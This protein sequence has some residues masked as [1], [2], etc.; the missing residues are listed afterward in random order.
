VMVEGAGCNGLRRHLGKLGV[1]MLGIV[2]P[3]AVAF[4]AKGG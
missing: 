3:Q 4:G 2:R 1:A